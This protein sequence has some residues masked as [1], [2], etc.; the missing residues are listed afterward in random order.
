MYLSPTPRERLATG[1]GSIGIV[2]LIGYVLVTGLTVPI[3]VLVEHPMAVLDLTEPPPPPPPEKQKPPEPHKIARPMKHDASPENLKARAT[4]IVAPPVPTPVKSPVIAA[5]RP[6]IGAAADNGASDRPGPGQGA[7]GVG[8]GLG[9]GG[10]GEGGD[11]PPHRIR[12]GLGFSDMPSALRAEGIE[13]TVAVRYAVN[14][15]GRVSNC[16][17]TGSSG[18]AELDEITC[19]LIEKR[20]RFE[21]SRDGS[22]QPVRSIIVEQHSWRVDRSRYDQGG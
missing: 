12:G 6:N 22:G 3:R 1:A 9:G 13:R 16:S 4:P 8:D 15:D 21:P 17:I 11:T 18:D 20:F 14:V 10:D 5:I 19:R 7:G 2:A